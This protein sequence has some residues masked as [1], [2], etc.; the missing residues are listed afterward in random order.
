MQSFPH[1]KGPPDTETEPRTFSLLLG[2]SADLYIAPIREKENAYFGYF[3][4]V[5]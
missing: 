3:R 1:R 2:H 4:E 5:V